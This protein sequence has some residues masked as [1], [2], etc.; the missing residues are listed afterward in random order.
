MIDKMKR[1]IMSLMEAVP[2]VLCMVSCVDDNYDL[3]DIDTNAGFNINNLVVPVNLDEISLRDVFGLNDDSQVQE[4]ANGYV[5]VHEGDFTSES[6]NVP[7]FTVSKP[8]VNPIEND[9]ELNFLQ[10]LHAKGKKSADGKPLASYEIRPDSTLISMENHNVDKAIVDIES[11][12]IQSD[13]SV[14]L[15]VS[16]VGRYLK[17][18]HLEKIR[19]HL[20]PGLTLTVS[21]GEYDPVTGDLTIDEIQ[22]KSGN[23]S[24]FMIIT[25][26]DLKQAGVK[27]DNPNISLDEMCSLQSGHISIFPED[28]KP[29]FEINDLPKTVGYRFT[30]IVDNVEFK[31]F[32]GTVRYDFDGLDIDPIRVRNLP[33]LINQD[34]TDIALDNP[35]IYVRVHNPLYDDYRLSARTSLELISIRDGVRSEP[36]APEEACVFDRKEN[37]FVFSPS[38]PESRPSGYDD[39]RH[40]GFS[41]LG[42]LLKGPRMPNS[43]EVNLTDP[44]I[45]TQ[46]VTDFRLGT[47]ID[48]VSGSYMVYAPMNLKKGSV[49]SYSDTIDGWNDDDLDPLT[50]T[51]LKI[52]AEVSTD[53]PVEVK[54]TA[55]PIDQNHMTYGDVKAEC[56]IPAYAKEFAMNTQISASIKHLDGIILKLTATAGEGKPL[57]P[58]MKIILR[59]VKATISGHYTKEL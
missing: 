56:T 42:D 41:S 16:N 20:I 3:S 54:L 58:D 32:T 19:F 24:I 28:L 29:D 51:D 45:P 14:N 5:F 59:N 21:E 1:Y 40:I 15:D 22:T 33:D 27:F 2:L 26:I 53:L 46:K 9:L 43:I 7:G 57:N 37:V 12:K 31:S 47:N 18:I 50:I 8:T 17:N 30:P 52:S 6:V 48:R 11:A 4:D 39:A 25:G 35:Q 55:V 23:V 34:G 13:I 38:V 10:P 44:C 49:I 36:L